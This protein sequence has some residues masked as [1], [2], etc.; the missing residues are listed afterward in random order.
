MSVSGYLLVMCHSMEE[1]KGLE[2]LLDYDGKETTSFLTSTIKY[3]RGSE[4]HK[5]TAIVRVP[6]TLTNFNPMCT[7]AGIVETYEAKHDHDWLGIR[8]RSYNDTLTPPHEP[9]L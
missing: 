1:S 9:M 2:R 3:F 7:P 5:Q 4:V 6:E 8:P